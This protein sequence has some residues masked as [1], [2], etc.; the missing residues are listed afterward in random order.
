[1]T[2]T[3]DL[4]EAKNSMQ[5]RKERRELRTVGFRTILLCFF[6]FALQLSRVIL[7][8]LFA[9]HNYIDYEGHSFCFRD[10]PCNC[11]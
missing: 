10:T 1:M 8:C 6:F 2:D 5:A 3:H 9:S 7:Q 4:I 11:I